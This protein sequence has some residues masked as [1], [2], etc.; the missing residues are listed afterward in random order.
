MA[1]IETAT[2]SGRLRGERHDGGAA[3]FTGIP[4]AA[5]PVGNLRFR[6][7]QPP[8][9]WSGTRDALT[10]SSIAPQNGSME[11]MLLGTDVPPQSEDCLYLNVWTPACDAAARPVMVWIHGGA[12][13]TGSSTNPFYDGTRF[14]LDGDVVIVTANYRVGTLGFCHLADVGGERFAG[15][16]NLGLLDQTA[17][18]VWV[19]DNVSQFGGDPGRVTIFGESAGGGSVTALMAAPQ[20]TGL[21]QQAIAQSASFRQFRSREHADDAAR[22]LLHELAISESHVEDLLTRPVTD[23]LAA[24]STVENG[25]NGI[26]AFAPTPDGVVLPDDVVNAL[27]TGL[28]SPR[29]PLLIGTNR[30][31]MRMFTAFDPSN[32]E[33]DRD[34]VVQRA[35]EEFGAARAEKLTDAYRM[36]LPGATWGQVASALATEH[37]FRQPAIHVATARAGHGYPTWMYR[38]DWESTA[39]GGVLGSCHALEI[40]FVFN[41]IEHPGAEMFSG[42][43]PNRAVVAQAMQHAWVNF[44]RHGDPGWAAYNNHRRPTMVF[45]DVSHV[46]DNPDGQLLHLWTEDER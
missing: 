13:V 45:N 3:T 7:P 37:G 22:R 12:Y 29:M 35:G 5:P 11:A 32:A 17:V 23:I 40:P 31:E 21:F 25:F 46:V 30:D 20:A 15:S 24:Q 10:R 28:A 2:T 9:S 6:P 1:W 44:A 39:F 19:R 18:L 38:F 26:M 33:M 42:G 36:A 16:G 14:A 41:T 34:A 43:G 27:T 4:Y 8:T